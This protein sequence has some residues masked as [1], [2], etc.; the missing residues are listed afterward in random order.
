MKQFQALSFI[1][2]HPFQVYLLEIDDKLFYILKGDKFVNSEA[3]KD[4]D[5]L[6]V[7]VPY[8]NEEE[9]QRLLEARLIDIKDD[10]IRLTETDGSKVNWDVIKYP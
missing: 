2:E 9:K 10:Y 4:R 1:A 7:I 8:K 5:V 3:W 6:C